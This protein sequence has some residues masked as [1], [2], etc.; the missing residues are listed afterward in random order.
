[1][2]DARYNSATNRMVRSE[3]DLGTINLAAAT[4]ALTAAQ[5]NEHFVGVVDA[6]FTL[7]AAAPA[8]K[9]VRYTVSCG[10]ASAGVGL[11][12]SPDAA[13]HIRGAGLTAVDNKDL[14]NPGATDVIGDCVS[15]DCDGVDGWIITSVAGTWAKEA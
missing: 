7:P 15:L 12:I 8:T 1:M 3:T 11:S 6:V 10:G 13:D 14:I 9:G 2:G 4:Q 5:S